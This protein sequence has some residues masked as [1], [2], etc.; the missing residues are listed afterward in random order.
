MPLLFSILLQLLTFAVP[1]PVAGP[2]LT[3]ARLEYGGGDR[4]SVV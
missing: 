1:P 2:E 3:I 4:K